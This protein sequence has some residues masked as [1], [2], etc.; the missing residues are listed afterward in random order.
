MLEEVAAASLDQG[1]KDELHHINQWL[2]CRSDAERTAT[3]YTIVQ[4]A[5]PIQIRFLITVLQQLANNSSSASL[6]DYPPSTPA[7]QEIHPTASCANNGK[8]F[9]FYHFLRRE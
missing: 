7:G 9:Y 8:F 1:F 5:S 3:L 6:H 2:R 4:N